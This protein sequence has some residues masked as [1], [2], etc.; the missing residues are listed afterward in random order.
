MK[1]NLLRLQRAH[2]HGAHETSRGDA[3]AC[4][5]QQK[6][7]GVGGRRRARRGCGEYIAKCNSERRRS[8][9]AACG[10]LCKRLTRSASS[11]AKSSGSSVNSGTVGAASFSPPDCESCKEGNGERA[12]ITSRQWLHW[13]TVCLSKMNQSG[14]VP[15][16]VCACARVCVC[17]CV[18]VR[19]YVCASS[20]AFTWYMRTIVVVHSAAKAMISSVRLRCTCGERRAHISAI[21]CQH[22]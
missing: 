15:L 8:A 21:A 4:R 3:R 5:C 18:F 13:F 10:V 16:T 17:V 14:S 1:S 6:A 11:L 12:F 20:A 7:R 2:S 19:A 22:V 9:S